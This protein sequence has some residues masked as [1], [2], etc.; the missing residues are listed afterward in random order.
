LREKPAVPKSNLPCRSLFYDNSVVAIA[1]N[2]KPEAGEYEITDVNKAYL[3]QGK[4]KWVHIRESWYS[5]ADTIGL[6]FNLMQ[7]ELAQVIE[8]ERNKV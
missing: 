4:L 1:K 5:L 3:E 2:I 6:L 7:A 8:R